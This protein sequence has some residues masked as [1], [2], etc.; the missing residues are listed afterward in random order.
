M[1]PDYY[2][3][4]QKTLEYLHLDNFNNPS[5]PNFVMGEE[6]SPEIFNYIVHDLITNGHNDLYTILDLNEKQLG[7][8]SEV[9]PL[10]ELGQDE[11]KQIH[12]KIVL[13]HN[14][15]YQGPVTLTIYRRS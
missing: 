15:Q 12:F 14:T 1:I 13:K 9:D 4:V 2:S 6:L 5:I 8:P 3:Q 10:E 11:F 7:I